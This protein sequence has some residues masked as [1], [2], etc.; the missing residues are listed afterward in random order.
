MNSNPNRVNS[1]PYKC[2]LLI[3][4]FPKSGTSSLH[5]LLDRSPEI[6]MSRPKECHFFARDSLFSRGPVFHNQLFS[7]SDPCQA[8][9]YGESSTIHC[10]SDQAILR[11]KAHLDNPKIILLVRDPLDRLISHYRWLFAKGTECL[12]FKQA[13]RKHGYDFN[14][15]KPIDGCYKGYVQF[16][17]YSIWI[18]K[19]LDVFGADNILL[20]NSKQLRSDQSQALKRCTEF[21]GIRS[22]DSSPASF[23]QTSDIVG[24]KKTKLSR[25]AHRLVPPSVAKVLKSSELLVS[26]WRRSNYKASVIR[27][28]L[29]S[30]NDKSYARDLISDDIKYYSKLFESSLP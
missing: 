19:W 16:S 2:N 29:I 6:C 1:S 18:P 9:Y 7:V 22:I 10:I 8:K 13:V 11:I 3:P 30:E 23:N 12:P 21:M 26:I 4:G 24:V 5:E 27:P 15:E 14:P 28:P 25:V 20:L 17:R